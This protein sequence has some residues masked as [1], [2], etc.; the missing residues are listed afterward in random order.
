MKIAILHGEVAKGAS[1]DE[2]DA[3]VEVAFVS[4]GLAQLGYEPLAVP[5][6]LNLER[7]TQAL[8]A[9]KPGLVFNLVES[10][11]GKGNLIHLV[12]ALLDSLRIPYTGARTEG[13]FLTSNKL[14]AKRTMAAAGLPTPAWLTDKEEAAQPSD[15]G[16]WIVK[17]LWEHASV[18]L[19]EDSVLFDADTKRLVE[20]MAARKKSLGGACFAEKFIDG[21]EFNVSLVAAGREAK[22]ADEQGR[23]MLA[24]QGARLGDVSAAPSRETDDPE[25]LP[26]AEIRFDA[27]PPGKVRVVGYRAKWEEESF[28][29]AGTTRTFVFSQR[30]VPLLARLTELSLQCWRLFDLRGYARV[31]F[32]VDSE[33]RPWILEVNANPCISPDAGFIA[34]AARA[35]ISAAEVFARIINDV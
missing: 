33:G 12:P 8:F 15:K 26:L 6:S 34:A 21:R 16:T 4:A 17:S 18:G 25:V 20:E 22:K 35:E 2:Q 7:L 10:L 5:V 30:D 29:F 27:Y 32:R 19:D 24:R 28:E 3:L 14:L 23:T 31:D 1:P 9:L 11:S 13:M